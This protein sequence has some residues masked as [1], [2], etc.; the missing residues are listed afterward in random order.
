MGR[1][2]ASPVATSLPDPGRRALL[3]GRLHGPPPLRPPWALDEPRFVDACTGCGDCVTA[4][5][6]NVLH[7]GGGRLPEFDPGRGECTFCGDCASACA[8]PAFNSVSALPWTLRARVGEACLTARGIVCSSCR[9]A[10]GE[11]AI[12]FPPTRAVP[13]PRIDAD[14]CTGCGACVAGCPSAAIS[15]AHAPREVADEA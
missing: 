10:C 13:V 12:R 8:A 4:C 11:A 3:R 5:P 6:E 2:V 9:D 15:L 1:A 14:R 7:L